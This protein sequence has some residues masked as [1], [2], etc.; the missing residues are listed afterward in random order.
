[1]LCIYF[2]SIKPRFQQ[3]A[4][5][6]GFFGHQSYTEVSTVQ[7]S[8]VRGPGVL[9]NANGTC[10]NISKHYVMTYHL[11]IKVA[12]TV[13]LTKV[14]MK[15]SWTRSL[16]SSASLTISCVTVLPLVCCW[17]TRNIIFTPGYVRN[18][19]PQV[20]LIT[21]LLS[22]WF[23]AEY[24]TT[25]SL[26]FGGSQIKWLWVFFRIFKK[27]SVVLILNLERTWFEVQS[28]LSGSGGSRFR[29][30]KFVP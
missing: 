8:V 3:W 26:N 17:P 29:I 4:I 21:R 15:S 10:W 27:S 12:L 9:K 2:I 11:N 25:K 16:C 5:F 20:F 6:S 22:S 13:R 24:T 18:A 14:S 30:L 23:G 1:M 19:F 28:F 7:G